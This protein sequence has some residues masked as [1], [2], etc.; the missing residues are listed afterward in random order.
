MCI[1]DPMHNLLLG[2]AKHVI[3]V[4]KRLSI[5]KSK[6][7]ADIQQKV[8]SFIAPPDIGRIPSKISSGFSGFTTDQW[9]N[10]TLFFSLFSLQPFLERPQLL[11]PICYILC[12]RSITTIGD[13]YLMGFCK[14]IVQLY[15][16]ENCTINMHLHGHLVE[17]IEDFGPVYSFWCFAYERMNGILG[18]YHVN[19]HHISIQLTRKFLDSKAYA[20][21]KWPRVYVDEYLPFLNSFTYHKGGLQQKSVETEIFTF[22][23]ETIVALP[24]QREYAL[25][26]RDQ[27]SISHLFDTLLPSDTYRILVLSRQTRAL[28]IQNFILGAAGSQTHKIV[29]SA[30]KKSSHRLCLPCGNLIFLAVYCNFKYFKHPNH[31]VDSCSQVVYG[32]SLPGLVWESN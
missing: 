3:E 29:S 9:K 28:L 2:T 12:R 5:L 18:S 17:C 11:E 30:C 7:F 31:T 10:W 25:E 13:K 8:D 23:S 22:K 27:V 15:G 26:Q 19:N 6:C 24:P 14:K 20:P 21:S 32:P 1:I 16:H 4:C